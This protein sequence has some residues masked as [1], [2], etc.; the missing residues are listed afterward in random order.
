MN[1][2]ARLEPVASPS[3]P[4][5][6]GTRGAIASRW[7]LAT[8]LLVTLVAVMVPFSPV[9]PGAGLDPSWRYAINQAVAQRLAFGSDLVFTFGPY[10]AVYTRM[11]HP[12]TD[13]LIL[14]GSLFLAFSYWACL[15]V[16]MRT[17]GR[18]WSLLFCAVLAGVVVLP[19]PLLFSHPLLVGLAVCKLVFA[20]EGSLLD[21]R[22]APWLIALLF[23]PF[24]LLPL[25]KGSNL[26]PC[27][28]I[29]GLCVVAF[30]LHRRLAAT[31]ACVA[32]PM[33]VLVGCW[34]AAGQALAALPGYFLAMAPIVS[35]YT[36]AMAIDGTLRD[37]WL[38]LAASGALLL[39]ILVQR[40]IEWRE[41]AFL[42]LVFS[43]YLFIT[44]KAGF[45][46][47]DGH[48]IIAGTGIV[49]AAFLLPFAFSSK[50]TPL[51][52]VLA[53]CAWWQVD[54]QWVNTTAHGFAD[55][56][57]GRYATAW[58][59]LAHRMAGDG[60]P[61]TEYRTAV[62]TLRAQARFPLL[63]GTSDI[64]PF[65]QAF[66]LASGNT[67]SPRP[68]LQSYSAYTPALAEMDRQFLLGKRAPD[69]IFFSVQPIDGRFPSIDDGASWPVLLQ[70]YKPAWMHRGFVLLK[71]NP[72]AG[73]FVE[74]VRIATGRYRFGQR[75]AL[76]ASAQPLF[77]QIEF[78]PTLPGAVAAVVYKPSQLQIQL[79]LAD[80][81]TKRFRMIAGMAR[82]GFLISPL[83][84][85]TSEFG[86]LYGPHGSLDGKR[87]VAMRMYLPGRRSRMWQDEFGLTLGRVDA[88]ASAD[89]SALVDFDAYD[90]SLSE[91]PATA[92]AGCQGSI[93]VVNGTT[94]PA[95]IAA[96]G[97]L[98]VDGWLA[99]ST[100]AGRLADAIYVVLT[101]AQGHRTYLTTHAS[102][103]PDLATGFNNPV[104]ADAGFSTA[105]DIS[106]FAGN[107]ELSL[108]FKSAGALASCPNI[109]IRL[110]IG[111]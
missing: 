85:S 101:D 102:S 23:A 64:Y 55:T 61:G 53:L 92:A 58:H 73:P 81:S 16:L 98:R 99:P 50:G 39:S 94:S 67:W 88:V 40:N 2:P 37:V 44:F 26:I 41:R 79:E 105:G 83:I 43:L 70:R 48:A 69:N 12:A 42:V 52:I 25:V 15:L 7:F 34:L 9:M 5:H 111:K 21:R 11:F 36:E 78:K 68:V 27:A 75:I 1:D 87:V 24:G 62:A 96:S 108:A 80:G 100:T 60:W 84:E 28:A 46:R 89:V 20:K 72:D 14:G 109:G 6:T 47:H 95:D 13:A 19:D 32:A 22:W 103:R 63:P 74:P 56:V 54:R 8:L 49:F 3:A 33:L 110:R 106:R 104:M 35:G 90:A 107:Y 97:S 38:Y 4:S 10:G 93:D 82:S 77:A 29:A 57:V 45:V 59:G 51:L 76:P 71:K 30:V 18:R 31:V 66:L 17:A 65:D 86:L 91:A